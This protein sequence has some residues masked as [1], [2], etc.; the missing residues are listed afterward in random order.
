MP[1]LYT[2][3]RVRLFILGPISMP[4]LC[5]PWARHTDAPVNQQ[6]LPHTRAYLCEPLPRLWGSRGSGLT[7]PLTH[8]FPARAC[9]S[10]LLGGDVARL[11]GS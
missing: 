1:P 9:Y 7:L 11:F 5:L 10:H 3:Y 2:T 8:I 6:L 4:P